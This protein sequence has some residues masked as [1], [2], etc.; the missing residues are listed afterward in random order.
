MLKLT[1]KQ[2]ALIFVEQALDL[3]FKQIKHKESVFSDVQHYLH[4]NLI[5]NFFKINI[6][7]SDFS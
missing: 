4:T 6:Y 3:S 7:S 5:I 2:H 1:L